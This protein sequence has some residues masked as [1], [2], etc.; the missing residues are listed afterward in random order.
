MEKK[1]PIFDMN[2]REYL[3]NTGVNKNIIKTLNDK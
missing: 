2:I 3:V 1:Y